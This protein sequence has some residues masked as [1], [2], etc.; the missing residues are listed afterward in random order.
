MR[1]THHW[2]SLVFVAAIVLHLRRTSPAPSGR[3]RERTWVV[4]IAVLLLAMA[5]GLAGH[6]L[7]D[8]SVVRSQPPDRLVRGVLPSR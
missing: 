5:Q 1:Q 2:A 8:D 4:G 7:P 6:S 3:P